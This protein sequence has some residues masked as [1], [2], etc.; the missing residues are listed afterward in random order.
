MGCLHLPQ[1]DGE[2][3]DGSSEE[4]NIVVT[5]WSVEVEDKW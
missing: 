4:K 5:L 1:E 3:G 2:D